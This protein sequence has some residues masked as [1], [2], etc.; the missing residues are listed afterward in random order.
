MSLQRIKFRTGSVSVQDLDDFVTAFLNLEAVT[1]EPQLFLNRTNDD[2]N[3][4]YGSGEQYQCFVITCD[5][6]EY[7]RVC[8]FDPAPEF[9]PE[10]DFP[11]DRCAETELRIFQI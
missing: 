1:R 9:S 4:G 3:V 2:V 8:R 6:D 5:G 11:G 7:I 10:V